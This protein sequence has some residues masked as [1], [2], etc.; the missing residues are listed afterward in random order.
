MH[1]RL[2]DGSDDV[3]QPLTST[4]ETLEN[5]QAVPLPLPPPLEKTED[6]SDTIRSARPNFIHLPP[7]PSSISEIIHSSIPTSGSARSYPFE[8]GL[9]I[10]V[11]DD[12]PMTRVLMKRLL[13][14]LGCV[15]TTAVNGDVA[16]GLLLNATRTPA[17][18]S[19]MDGP[20][21]EQP[22]ASSPTEYGSETQSRFAA[23]FLDN[24]MPILTGLETVR[25]LRELGRTDF[26]VGVTGEFSA[27]TSF[28]II[29]CSQVHLQP[30]P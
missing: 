18:P 28:V 24:F 19:D 27:S 2:S 4:P 21:L 17:S 11:V 10:L 15:V 29:L 14:R 6:S 5:G 25:K 26:I 30:T 9:E 1:K 16:L 22:V 8:G 3:S 23:V 7:K 20:I 12:D 13:E